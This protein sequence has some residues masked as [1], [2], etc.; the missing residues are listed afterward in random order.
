MDGA[1]VTGEIFMVNAA[2]EEIGDGL[3]ASVGTLGVL[4]M[5]REVGGNGGTHTDQG[6]QRRV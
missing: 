2:L 4:V 6:N 1:L 3:L 5:R